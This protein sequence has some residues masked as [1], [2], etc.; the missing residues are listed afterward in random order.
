MKKFTFVFVFAMAFLAASTWV[1]VANPYADEAPVRLNAVADQVQVDLDKGFAKLGTTFEKAGQE[2]GTG[3]GKAG[4]ALDK[5]TK[6]LDKILADLK[7]S[8]EP[9]IIISENPDATSPVIT[10]PGSN[11]AVGTSV[12]TS[13]AAAA[14]QKTTEAVKAA[15]G[16]FWSSLKNLF[17][18]VGRWAKS[19]WEQITGPSEEEAPIVNAV[20]KIKTK[21]NQGRM[22]ASWDNFLSQTGQLVSSVGSFFKNLFS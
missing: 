16:D 19:F 15:A 4:K 3:L 14:T 22:S 2:L 1:L 17:T 6:D 11:P 8:S 18:S 21:F 7:K 12:S 13:A 20:N 9:S 10:I 5:L